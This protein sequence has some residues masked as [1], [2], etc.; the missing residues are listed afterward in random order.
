MVWYMGL[1]SL[2]LLWVSQ[3]M[4]HE[5]TLLD[6]RRPTPGLHIELTELPLTTTPASATPRYRLY[7]FGFPRGVVFD[8][9]TRDFGHSFHEIASGFQMDDSGVMVSHK[10]D[11]A[12][13]VRRWWRWL[14][15]GRPRRLDEMALAPGPYYPRGAVWEVALA[16][17]DRSLT[18]FAKVIPYP[19]TARDG[20]C[21]VSL[22]LASRRADRFI[23]S[24][25]GFDPGDEVI[26]ESRHTERIIQKRWR[27][28]PEGLLPRNVIVHGARGADH[29][30]RYVVKG[31][32]CNVVV[33][34]EWG[35]SAL[36]WR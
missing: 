30:A 32:A 25:T 28:S 15:N 14:V 3:A 24:G 18:A 10:S 2:L 13:W 20:A 26:T 33:E 4:T 7:T 23:A 27:I 9:W 35:K 8:V 11:G 16:S 12:S 5:L 34:Y 22:E 1:A 36:S 6:N 21:T 17:V 19:I 29:S 31:R